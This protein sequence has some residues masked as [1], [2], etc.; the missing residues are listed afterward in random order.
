MKINNTLLFF[1][2]VQIVLGQEKTSKEIMGQI[3]EIS[4][5]VEGVNIINNTTQQTTVS[6]VNGM[7]SIAVK[8]GDVLVFSAVN[9]ESVK[10]RITKE[11]LSLPSIQVKIKAKETELKEVIVNEN[12][13]INAVS[14]GIVPKDQKR[15][16]NAE[17]KLATAGDFKPIMLLGLLGGSMA[18]D[19]LLNK[20]SGRT[21][22]LKKNIK[23]EKKE[24]SIKQLSNMFE[25]AYFIERLKIS[26]EYISGFKFYLVEND[27]V[28]VLLNRKEK[29][30]LELLMSEMA[31]KYNEII[32]SENK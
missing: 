10:R 26:S 17:R 2:F 29:V 28:I 24:I 32:L 31:L 5:P 6:E 7:F 11:D 15:Y 19:P 16:T 21:K 30:R 23:V 18:L 20:I 14:L 4:V 8:E 3:L 25:D 13:S 9:L 22:E 27:E 12:A 1:L